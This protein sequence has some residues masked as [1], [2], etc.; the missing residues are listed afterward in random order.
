[1]KVNL[2]LHDPIPT[3]ETGSKIF[4]TKLTHPKLDGELSFYH[5]KNNRSETLDAITTNIIGT[6][7]HRVGDAIIVVQSGSGTSTSGSS[8][9]TAI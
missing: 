8:V 7:L 4:M 2:V 9:V 3:G 1:M 6:P 5:G